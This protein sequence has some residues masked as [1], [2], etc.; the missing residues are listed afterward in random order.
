MRRKAMKP[1]ISASQDMFQPVS[2]FFH[3]AEWL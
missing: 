3:L 1:G 2:N